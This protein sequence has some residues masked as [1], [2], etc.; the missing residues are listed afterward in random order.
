MTYFLQKL[1][2]KLSKYSRVKGFKD[3]CDYFNIDLQY[4]DNSSI[5]EFHLFTGVND[6]R[7]SELDQLKSLDWSAIGSK[8]LLIFHHEVIYL[9]PLCDYLNSQIAKYN[10]FGQ[11]FYYTYNPYDLLHK[12]NFFKCIYINSISQTLIETKFNIQKNN[13]TKIDLRRPTFHYDSFT[14]HIRPH[15]HFFYSLLKYHNILEK[16]IYSFNQTQQ[17]KELMDYSLDDPYFSNLKYLSKDFLNES[18]N[19][20]IS[21]DLTND[22][23]HIKYTQ[24][25]YT[26]SLISNSLLSVVQESTCNQNDIF[27][28]E[29]TWLP[30]CSGKP[31]LLISNFQSL[32][33]LKSIFKLKTFSEVFDESYDNIFDPLE[34]TY[35]VFKEVKRFSSLPLDE[36][37]RQVLLLSEILNYNRDIMFNYSHEDQFRSVLKKIFID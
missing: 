18:L 31:F 22:W 1:P 29:K 36:A 24:R 12:K 13:P 9:A 27:L 15:R 33:L 25:D 2:N 30:L 32:R 23:D 26:T 6:L 19:D 21:I 20:T 8:K 17:Y 34:R 5:L 3:Y 37:R 16:G 10:L 14:Y 7:L 28:T 4:S 11:V 35:A